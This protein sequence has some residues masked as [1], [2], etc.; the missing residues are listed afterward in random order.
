MSDSA[1]S[2]ACK[3]RGT[4]VGDDVDGGCECAGGKGGGCSPS[5]PMMRKR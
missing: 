2:R 5:M 4:I 3:R 1:L